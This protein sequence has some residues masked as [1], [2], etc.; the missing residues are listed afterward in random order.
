M[1]RTYICSD[2]HA[3][4]GNILKYC[5]RTEFM[6]EADL[7]AFRRLGT[8]S[9]Y[10]MSDESVERMNCG[11][12]ANINARVGPDDVLWCLGDWCFGRGDAYVRHARTFRELIACRNVHLI[13]GN[14]DTPKL[15]RFFTSVSREARLDAEGLQAT[16]RHYP[17]SRALT[18]KPGIYLHGHVHRFPPAQPF[19]DMLDGWTS[20]DVGLDG[21]NYQAWSIPEIRDRLGC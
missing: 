2:P 13:L 1:S 20:L 11:L 18:H 6:T 16:L 17:P 7:E 10:R 8:S 3:F 14:H 9:C 21:N 12:A 19:R 4:H 5:A 15:R